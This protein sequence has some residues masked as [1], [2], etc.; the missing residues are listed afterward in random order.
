[1]ER[2]YGWLELHLTTQI[3]CGLVIGLVFVST[4][5]GMLPEVH[6]VDYV[7]RERTRNKLNWALMS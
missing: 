4:Y 5:N 3:C 2:S 1:M 6:Y 7:I